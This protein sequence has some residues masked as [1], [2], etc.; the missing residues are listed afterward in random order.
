MSWRIW[1]AA[2]LLA[3]GAHLVL[4]ASLV[5]WPDRSLSTAIDDGELGLEVGLG[6]EGGYQDQLE[7][8]LAK[9]EPV[10]PEPSQPDRRPEP[11]LELTPKLVAD[12]ADVQVTKAPGD[13]APEPTPEPPAPEPKPQPQT[14]PKLK[15]EPNAES[16]DTPAAETKPESEPASKSETEQP[17][18][19]VASKA[20]RQSTGRASQERAGGTKGDAKSYFANLMAWLHQHKDYPPELKKEKLQGVVVIKFSIN[21]SGEVI[22]S[23][24]KTGSGHASLDR[25]ALDMLAR[26]NPVPPIPESMGRER[27]TLAIPIEYSLITR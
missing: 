22:S 20:Q 10:L 14:E 7:Q 13:T 15:P 4:A 12:E 1:L 9:P 17:L 21:Q 27:L 5:A 11:E 3:I 25:A 6:R 2:L 8:H 24:I 18:S 19:N 26:A 16:R 23:G